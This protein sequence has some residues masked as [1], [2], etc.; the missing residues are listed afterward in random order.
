MRR[1]EKRDAKSIDPIDQ[2]A[3]TGGEQEI[4]I[5]SAAVGEARA[6]LCVCFSVKDHE[7]PITMTVNFICALSEHVTRTYYTAQVPGGLV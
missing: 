2:A 7:D 1:I 5:H 6:G 3:L 4:K